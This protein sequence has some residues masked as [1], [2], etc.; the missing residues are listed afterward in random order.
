MTKLYQNIQSN[1]NDFCTLFDC[2]P[3]EILQGAGFQPDY[4]ALHPKGVDA[5]SFYKLTW[6]LDKKF[7]KRAYPIDVL[8]SIA[9][10][11]K[12]PACQ[13]MAASP[14]VITGLQRLALFKSH[15]APVN[16]EI[17]TTTDLIE[18]SILPNLSGYDLPPIFSCLAIVH[19]IERIR[20]H[21]GFYIKP[22]STTID[23]LG[24]DITELTDFL[25]VTPSH[26]PTAKI[27]IL[28]EDSLRPFHAQI[29][30]AGLNGDHHNNMQSELSLSVIQILKHLLP[31]GR[32]SIQDVAKAMGKSSRSLQRELA[33][34][35]FKYSAL[36]SETRSE[37]AKTYISRGDLSLPEISYLLAYSEPSAF[38][39]AY[40][41]WTG[42]TPRSAI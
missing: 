38:F 1:F 14:D 26:G 13:A 6:S 39:R 36:L 25:G 18:I 11:V 22:V 29:D 27:V 41:K 7:E 16:F 3:I 8:R 23:I 9:M 33:N 5:E 10:S 19:M 42:K 28:I 15:E 24:R 20:V 21:S 12:S 32:S 2:S 37:L 35:N 31:S 30:S 40:K 34:Q 4:M 17:K